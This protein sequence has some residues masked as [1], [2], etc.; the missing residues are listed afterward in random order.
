MVV[1]FIVSLFIFIISRRFKSYG[2]V[3]QPTT[4]QLCRRGWEWAPSIIWQAVWNYAAGPYLLYKIRVIRDIYNWRLQTTIAIIAG[5]A[6]HDQEHKGLITIQLIALLGPL[7]QVFKSRKMQKETDQALLEFDKKNSKGL[8]APNASLSTT[9]VTEVSVKTGTSSRYSVET[10]ENCINTQT[11]DLDPFRL[12]CANRCLC[13]ENVSFLEKVTNFKREWDR[14]FS[15]PGQ[16][17]KNARLIMYR[18][19]INIYLILVNENTAEFPINIEGHIKNQ[20]NSLFHAVATGIAARVPSIAKSTVAAATP[21]DEPADPFT[22]P[23]HGHH[24][25]PLTRHS[26]DKGSSTD[27]ITEINSALDGE[28]PFTAVPAAFDS[29]CFDRA[30]ASIT[31]MLWQQPWQEYMR[32]KR[33]S[34]VSAI[35]SA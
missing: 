5:Y 27:L 18:V 21:W 14:I 10:L 8:A 13:V 16:D 31:H 22:N 25:Q 29:A 30:A 6:P 11:P 26:L 28:G 24:L 35:S 32:S 9:S 2:I 34:T 20:L 12:F 1:Q 33:G 4:L 7:G 17:F 19:A 15:V 23:G 3:S